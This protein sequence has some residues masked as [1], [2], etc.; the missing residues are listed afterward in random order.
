MVK[1]VK[2]SCISFLTLLVVTKFMSFGQ[3]YTENGFSYV[4]F[5]QET[6]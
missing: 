1:E 3:Y 5:R 6:M 4:V 2:Q